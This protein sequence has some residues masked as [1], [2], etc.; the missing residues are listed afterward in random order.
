[1]EL[2]KELESELDQDQQLDFFSFKKQLEIDKEDFCKEVYKERKE[3]IQIKKEKTVVK[4]L[5]K[6]FDATFRICTRKGFRGMSM[7]D[8]S[9]E[10]GLSMGA[11]YSYFRSKEE[12]LNTLQRVGNSFIQRILEESALGKENAFI[13]LRL[14]IKTHLYLS[15]IVQPWFYFSYMEAKSLCKKE[16][17]FYK[18]AELYTENLILNIL[19]EG[20]EQGLFQQR[21]HKMAASVIKAML[22][23]WYL[24][25]WK[26]AKRNVTVDHYADFILGFIESFYLL[27]E[28]N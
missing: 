12:L 7:R 15:E 2:D 3:S 24:K 6:I 1:M 19:E 23:D 11:L 13:R 18:Q 22:Q 16:R 20:A 28:N 5:E 9:Q 26:Y 27:K 25:R 4:N 14:T 21:E 8:L 17:D 10:S